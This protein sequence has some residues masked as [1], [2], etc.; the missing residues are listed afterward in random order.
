L[1]RLLLTLG[2]GRGLALHAERLAAAHT[3]RGFRVGND[4]AEAEYERK[5]NAD[6]LVHVS[7]LWKA[8]PSHCSNPYA[9]M[10][11]QKCYGGHSR[12]Q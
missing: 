8:K 12:L 6:E 9:R 5:D 3:A 7:S 4:D 2:R 11:G 1:R 10:A